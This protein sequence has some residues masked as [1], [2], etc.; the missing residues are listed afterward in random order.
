MTRL[1]LTFI[2]R[3]LAVER[4]RTATTVLGVA[5]GVAVVIAIQLANASSVR[6]FATALDT[7]SGRAAIEIVGSGGGLD[8][9]VMPSLGWLR[10][11]GVVSPVIEG[12]MAA[13][14]G[15]GRRE[16]MRVLGVDILRDTAIRDYRVIADAARDKVDELPVARIPGAADEPT[17]P[18]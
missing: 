18:S 3:H 11:F 7:M 13:V 16:A 12:T 6:G 10:E 9:T 1:F 8:E 14:F 4:L 5:L 2:V 17:T 15:D